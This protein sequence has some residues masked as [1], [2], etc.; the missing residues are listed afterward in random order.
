MMVGYPMMPAP[1]MQVPM[2][3]PGTGSIRSVQSVPMLSPPSHT[4]D[5]EPCPVHHHHPMVPLA[6]LYGQF[7]V[8]IKTLANFPVKFRNG[9]RRCW[10]CSIYVHGL[11]SPSFCHIR[12][13]YGEKSQVSG[14]TVTARSTPRSPRSPLQPQPPTHPC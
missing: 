12:S 3:M 13:N 4:W 8:K 1:H 6:A 10:L 7:G 2:M 11:L 14:R 5:G 9:W